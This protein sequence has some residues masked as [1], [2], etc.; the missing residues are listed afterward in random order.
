LILLTAA[1]EIAVRL[2]HTPPY[3]LPAPS[4][5]AIALW[6]DF[7]T[8]ARHAAAT[9]GETFA[10]LALAA[11][12]GIALAILMDAFR[13]FRA[14][15]YPLLVVSQT[16]PVIVLAPLFIIYLG[17]GLAPKIITVALMCFFPV[18]VSFS[19][20][21]RSADARYVNL[22]RSFGAR[23]LKTYLLVKL[24]AAAPALFSSLRVAATYS[25]TGAVVGEWLSSDRG[26]GF[27]MLRVKNAYRLDAV[28]ASVLVV[29][30]LSMGMNGLIRILRKILIRWE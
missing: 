19:D 26:L 27:Y 23:R 12:A 15:A 6:R 16:V 11:A 7:P 20:A 5:V 28:F 13:L 14:S 2:A 22:V 18:A 21:M 9:L 1:W 25:V 29:A 30:L 24:P 17:F 4:R 10:G 8:L 3:V